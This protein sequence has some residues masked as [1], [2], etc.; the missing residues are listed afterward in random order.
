VDDFER[1]NGLAFSPDESSLYIVDTGATHRKEG[2]RHIRRFT[3]EPNGKLTGGDIF[4]SCTAGLFDGIRVD[5]AGR[6]WTSAEDGVHCYDPDGTLLG[7]ILVPE[8]VANL[9]F[10]GIKRNRLFICG[11]SSLYSVYVL[12]NGVKTF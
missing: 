11:T 10:G 7:K 12:I 2:P 1:P 6:L 5:E 8:V 9:V 3:V 4:A